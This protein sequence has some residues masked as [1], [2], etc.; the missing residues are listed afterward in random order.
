[1]TLVSRK[2]NPRLLDQFY[3]SIRLGHQHC[4]PLMNGDLR[5]AYLNLE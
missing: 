4:L 2:Y 5:R 1:M 3:L